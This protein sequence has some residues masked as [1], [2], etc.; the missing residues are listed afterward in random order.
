MIGV[1]HRRS[2]GGPDLCVMCF[3]RFFVVPGTPFDGLNPDL[4]AQIDI[5]PSLFI[6]PQARKLKR[7]KL[8]V[9]P[10]AQLE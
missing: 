2:V 4:S 10:N 3:R 6:R 7:Y 9:I 5:D 8:S 1:C